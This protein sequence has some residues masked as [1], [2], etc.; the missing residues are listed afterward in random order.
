MK[1]LITIVMATAALLNAV[2]VHGQGI[3]L[4]QWRDHLPYSKAISVADAGKKVYCATPYSVFYYD[5]T[6][7]SVSRLTKVNGLSDIGISSLAYSEEY[8]SLVIAYSNTNIDLLQGGVVI[9]I[10]DIKRKPILGKKS[11]NRVVIHDRYAYLCCGFGIVVLDLMKNEIKDTYYIGPE[12]DAIEVFDL[13]TG[14]G[15]FFAATE[16]G[17]YMAGM[18]HPNLS[19]YAAWNRDSTLWLPQRK[20]NTLAWFN[21]KL[22]AN[23]SNQTYYTDTLFYR[24]AGGWHY[25]SKFKSPTCHSLQAFDSTLIYVCADYIDVMD[26]GLI[27]GNRIW[28]YY[29]DDTSYYPQPRQA[30]MDKDGAVWIADY[31]RGLLKN[32]NIWAFMRVEPNGPSGVN[33]FAMTSGQ[34]RV[35][36]VP[37]GRNLT[38]GNE[39]TY[40]ALHTFSD[41]NWSS[42]DNSSLALMDS[43][44]DFITVVQDP[45]DPSHV[46]AGT[47]GFGLAEFRNDKLVA[48]Y[49]G[50]NSVL[51]P[52]ATYPDYQV[53]IGGLQ[54]DNQQNL[55]IVNSNTQNLLAVRKKNGEWASF[56]LGNLATGASNID[57]GD[58]CIDRYGQKWMLLRGNKLLVFSDNNTL[59]QTSDDKARMLGAGIGNGNIPGSRVRSIAADLEGLV[60]LGTDEGVAVFYAPE[61]VFTAQNVDAQRIYVTQDGYTQYL[62]ETEAVTAIAVDGSNKKWFGTEKAGVFLMSA[63]G[64]E[65]IFHFTEENSPLLSNSI[66]SITIDDLSGEVFFGTENG[67]CSFKGFATR[68]GESNENVYAYPNPVEQGYDGY[69]AV[70]GLVRDAVVKF[71]DINGRLVYHTRAEGGQAIWNGRDFDGGKVN[72]GVYLVYVSNDDGSETYVTKILFK[73]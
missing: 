63:D 8:R 3:A 5:R 20:F 47:W 34:G 17:I 26:T 15:Q 50:S 59:T 33:V 19:N 41:E 67:I 55:W 46:F 6:D 43:L 30:V 40:G 60:W 71:T 65:E 72:T 27:I 9:N 44:R 4:G 31:M 56:N 13:A 69:I 38:W 51:K 48:V 18:N 37:G 62:L 32:T 22:Y 66:T 14:N 70:R 61:N 45:A 2:V 58:F 12:G 23:Q 28:A 64:T 1:Y 29:L 53:K 7:N 73:H 49:E 25:F 21:G 16:K 42:I 11:I 36:V 39:W 35:R 52:P 24:D 68:G 10:P 54:Y 57:I